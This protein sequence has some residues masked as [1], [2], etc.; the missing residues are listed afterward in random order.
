MYWTINHALVHNRA[1]EFSLIS[2]ENQ[3]I[4]YIK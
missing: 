2:Y 4:G 3:A 1:M